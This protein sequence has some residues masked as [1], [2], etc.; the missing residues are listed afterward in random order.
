MINSEKMGV[1]AKKRRGEWGTN[2]SE[3]SVSD[4]IPDFQCENS[5]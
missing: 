2:S 3:C 1:W 5:G 4:T